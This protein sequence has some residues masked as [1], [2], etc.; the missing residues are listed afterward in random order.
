MK[1]RSILKKHLSYNPQLIFDRIA[2][3]YFNICTE[4]LDIG[5]GNGRLIAHDPVRIE[6]LDASTEAVVFCRGKGFKVILGAATALPYNDQSFSGVHC[7]HLIEHLQP[8]D[9]WKLISEMNR[10]LKKDGILCLRAPLMTPSFY[11]DLTHVKPYPPQAIMHS[12]R[13]WNSSDPQ[14]KPPLDSEYKVLCLKWRHMQMGNSFIRQ[15]FL[16][17]ILEVMAHFGIREIRRSGY[18]LILKKTM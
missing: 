6:G 11:Y 13:T 8:D 1:L 10:I 2:L 18:L 5:C 17:R 14:S 12:L 3:D 7:S 15:P 9:A 16:S 4:I